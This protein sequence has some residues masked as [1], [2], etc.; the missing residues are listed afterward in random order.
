MNDKKLHLSLRKLAVS[1]KRAKY[2]RDISSWG[3]IY[4]ACKQSIYLIC[5]RITG[6]QQDAE[7][8]TSEVFIR[9]FEKLKLYDEHKPILPWLQTIAYHQ[10]IDFV[11]ERSRK[12]VEDG[13]LE[14][15]PIPE[16]PHTRIEQI[17]MRQ[18]ILSVARQLK[19]EQRRCFCL[20]YFQRKSYRE[21]AQLTGYS[22]NEVRSHL[23]NGR[24]KFKQLYS[25]LE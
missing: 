16:N 18:Q 15:L 7:D 6:S 17:E 2:E 12:Q 10:S 3:T 24:R 13:A 11:R 8:L 14:E 23:Q 1:A 22:V 19:R 20:F 21:I 25:K 4:E 5:L 9:G